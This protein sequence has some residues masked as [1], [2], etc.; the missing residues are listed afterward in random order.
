MTELK[1][2]AFVALDFSNINRAFDTIRQTH[3]MPPT[4][5]LNYER[6]VSIIT[7]GDN[8]LSKNVYMGTKNAVD[9]TLQHR[10]LRYFQRNGFNIVTKE[11]KVIKKIDG[12][13]IRKANFDDKIIYDIMQHIWNREC[14]EI[15][16]MSGD[17]DFAYVMDRIK[18][19]GFKITIVSSE[20]TISGELRALA[21][22]LILIDYLDLDYLR[23]DKPVRADQK[24]SFQ[25]AA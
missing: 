17:S 6:L 8:L 23:F 1:R 13:K 25:I 20:A 14:G 16:L 24:T 3:A 18:K 2:K 15:V 19:L 5:K 12:T 11:C 7:P 22:D 4:T 10:F 9:P 21:D